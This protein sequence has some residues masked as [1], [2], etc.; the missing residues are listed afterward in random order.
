VTL[1]VLISQLS[2]SRLSMQYLHQDDAQLPAAGHHS[3][4]GGT[5]RV[6]LGQLMDLWAYSQSCYKSIECLAQSS[7]PRIC[8]P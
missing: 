7:R 5:G 6:T 3:T 4:G 8:K 1:W 2:P